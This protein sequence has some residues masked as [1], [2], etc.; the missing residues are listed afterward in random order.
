MYILS[1]L[2]LHGM[3]YFVVFTGSLSAK[4]AKYKANK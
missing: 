3:I 4:W 2:M 1:P